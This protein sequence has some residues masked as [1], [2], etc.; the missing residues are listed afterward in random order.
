[1]RRRSAERRGSRAKKV[2][3]VGAG[4]GGLANAM[5]LAQS[6]F[7][8]E[9]LEKQGQVGGRTSTISENGF[10]FDLGPTFF[11]YP[12]VLESIFSSCGMDL[13]DEVD[14]IRLDPHYRLLF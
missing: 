6:G 5:L 4:P 1:M 2:V 12:Q 7:D 14:L 9:V 10:N 3:I 11:L 8:V 13:N